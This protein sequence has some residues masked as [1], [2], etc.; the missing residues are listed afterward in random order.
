[1]FRCVL[2]HSGGCLPATTQLKDLSET[3]CSVFAGMLGNVL[4]EVVCDILSERLCDVLS[5]VLCDALLEMFRDA[6]LEMFSTVLSS[7][8]VSDVLAAV[9]AIVRA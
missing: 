4:S 6:L 1:M 8:R 3:L 9:A 7:Q 2:S 5:E